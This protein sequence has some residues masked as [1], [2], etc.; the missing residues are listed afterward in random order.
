MERRDIKMKKIAIVIAV[1]MVLGM[2]TSMLPAAEKAPKME[3]LT[4]EVV[5]LDAETG[6]IVIMANGEEQTLNAEPK[7][8]KGIEIGD[9]VNIE[10]S[11]DALKSIKK[12]LPPAVE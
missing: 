5:D 8:L 12:A 9:K 2:T 6:T 3:M 7:L 11:G 10:K 1:L 4:G